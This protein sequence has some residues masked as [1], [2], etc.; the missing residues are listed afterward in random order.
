MAFCDWSAPKLWSK[1]VQCCS[2]NHCFAWLS[3]CSWYYLTVAMCL[4]GS[5]YFVQLCQESAVSSRV[6]MTGN[7]RTLYPI[8]SDLLL[9]VTSVC[10]WIAVKLLVYNETVALQYAVY[11]LL[12]FVSCGCKYEVY[13]YKIF[14][15]EII[16]YTYCNVYNVA[17]SVCYIKCLWD[18]IVAV[19]WWLF[20]MTGFAERTA[21]V[22]F[23]GL[24]CI[25]SPGV[26]C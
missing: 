21:E 17:C 12:Y 7:L 1:D 4:T 25:F 20:V 14:L 15:I 11:M 23:D 9:Y 8:N 18:W 24:C 6:K 19:D 26:C 13:W 10:Y 2:V 16:M 5:S 3:Y 22:W